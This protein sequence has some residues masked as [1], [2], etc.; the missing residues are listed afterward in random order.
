VEEDFGP[1]DASHWIDITPTIWID[2]RFWWWK[3]R[4]A[5]SQNG[6]KEELS[7]S[8]QDDDKQPRLHASSQHEDMIDDYIAMKMSRGQDI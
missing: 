8:R 3:M 6:S 4:M 7:C 1:E 2:V 5:S